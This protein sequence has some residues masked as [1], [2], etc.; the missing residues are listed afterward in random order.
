MEGQL[1]VSR[2]LKKVCLSFWIHH[3]WV[4][5]F[6]FITKVKLWKNS[7]KKGCFED[8]KPRD[9]MCKACWMKHRLDSLSVKD[10]IHTELQ[11]IECIS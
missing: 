7:N 3:I 6:C 5:S 10:E 4:I 1:K 11:S 8:N 9:N 2:N